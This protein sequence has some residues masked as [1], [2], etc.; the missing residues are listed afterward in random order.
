MISLSCIIHRKDLHS[1]RSGHSIAEKDIKARRVRVLDQDVNLWEQK[2]FTTDGQGIILLH[3]KK[4]HQGRL[5]HGHQ[6]T[7]VRRRFTISLSWH[8]V[9][10][11]SCIYHRH[12]VLLHPAGLHFSRE[13]IAPCAHCANKWIGGGGHHSI[14]FNGITQ[15]L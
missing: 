5:N 7:I 12:R 13:L 6:L 8:I 15:T 2:L 3:F 1:V 9:T 4:C 10:Q 11:S 14:E